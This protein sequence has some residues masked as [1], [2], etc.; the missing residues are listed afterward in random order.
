MN[1]KLKIIKMAYVITDDCTACGTC[2]D[3][4]PVEAI[5][6]G[7]IYK[8]DPELFDANPDLRIK[9]P[10]HVNNIFS[11]EQIFNFHAYYL[12]CPRISY[13]HLNGTRNTTYAF[14]EKE[15][16]TNQGAPGSQVTNNKNNI[17]SD[18][19]Q[20]NRKKINRLIKSVNANSDDK[21]LKELFRNIDMAS[22]NP[23]KEFI[24]LNEIYHAINTNL[25]GRNDSI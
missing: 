17:I 2:I 21:L 11:V 15:I 8:I 12:S 13:I 18:S 20:R 14:K 3:E 16:K 23:D 19:E 25:G 6:E 22:H 24:F 1:L 9:I 10:N 7:D 4:C 5:S